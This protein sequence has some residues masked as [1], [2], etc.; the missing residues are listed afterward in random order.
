MKNRF[1]VSVAVNEITADEA[2]S[3]IEHAIP[4][5]IQPLVQV[6]LATSK[7]ANILQALCCACFPISCLDRLR[8]HA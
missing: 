7:T 5:F 8:S 2:E 4:V 3:F 6:V 1:S